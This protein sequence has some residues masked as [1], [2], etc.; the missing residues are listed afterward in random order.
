MLLLY[1]MGENLH[2]VYYCQMDRN[3][4]LNNRV[5]KRNIPSHQMGMAYFSR[6]VDTYATVMPVLDCHKKSKVAKAEFPV[7]S[8]RQI[9]NPGSGA[10]YNGFAKNVDI[11]TIL[12]GT[13]KPLQ[14]CSQREYIPSSTSDLYRPGHIINN[15]PQKMT[16]NG[17]FKKEHFNSFNPNKC[18]LGHKL[19][20]N[21]MR[22]QMKGVELESQN[23]KI[24]K[25]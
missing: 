21:H 2:D 9:F 10:P 1:I 23:N 7:Y 14:K 20:N 6:P 19:F 16:H 4:E 13:T 18:N 11:E 8:Q 22:L 17:L 15:N 12:H 3:M 25:N 5:Y 24:R